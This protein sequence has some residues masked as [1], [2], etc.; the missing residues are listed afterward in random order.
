MED[1]TKLIVDD[2]KIEE[3]TT[4]DIDEVFEVE[5]IVLKIIGQKSLLEKSCLMK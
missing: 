2:I 5:K 4:E 1:N 3:M